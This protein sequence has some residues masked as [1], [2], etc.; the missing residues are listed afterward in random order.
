MKVKAILAALVASAAVSSYGAISINWLTPS[1]FVQNDGTTPL[2]QD[3]PT[4]LFQLIYSADNT[5]GAANADGSSTGDTILEEIVVNSVDVDVDASFFSDVYSQ[6]FTSGFVYLRVFEAGTT[7]G[8]TPAG[9][10]YF[11]GPV[12]ATQDITPPALDQQ[13]NEGSPGGGAGPSG[14]YILNQQV[15][16]PEPGVLAFLGIGSLL[17]VVRRFRRS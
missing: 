7:V 6:P 12:F 1:G 17:M 14:R 16:V 10:W 13:V 11:T 3:T 9:T 2:L 15:P 4:A 5:A 8:N